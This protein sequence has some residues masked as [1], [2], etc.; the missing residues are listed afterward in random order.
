MYEAQQPQGVGVHRPRLRGEAALRRQRRRS[1]TRRKGFLDAVPV[2]QA[3]RRPRRRDER[4]GRRRHHD[5]RGAPRRR[6]RT[7]PLIAG[8]APDD[9][10]G[11]I[12]TSG[13]TG[14]P[15]GVILTHCN[16]ASNVSAV[17][18]VFPLGARP[19]ARSRSSPGRT[20]RADRASSTRSS[21][22]GAS[23]ALCEAVDKIIDNLAEVQPDA[24][25]QRAAHLQP[26][27]HGGAEA[28]RRRS[29]SRSRT[30][31]EGR[32]QGHRQGA[33]RRAPRRSR[34]L[35]LAQLVDKLVFS[36][37]RAR[38][39]GRL[40]YAVQRRRGHLARGGRVHRLARHHRL[41]GLRPHRDEPH[42]HGQLPRRAEDRQ[43]RPRHPGRAHRDRRRHRRAQAAPRTASR[44][45]YEGEIVVY[46]PNVMKG[47]HNRPEENAAVF[48]KDGGFRTGDMGYLDA[49]GFLYITG[50]IKE[51]YKLENGKYV[52]P[53]P[54]EEQ[55][56]LSPL[57]RQRDGLRRQQARSTWRSS[58]P[59]STR[60]Q[61][62]GAKHG[63][64]RAGDADALLAERAGARALQ[65]GDREARAG[66]SRASS[67]SRT[68]RSSPRTSRPTTGC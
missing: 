20:L 57:R 60:V 50:R 17:H 35:A 66:S 53:T 3:H 18:E 62:V 43:R 39:G 27:L 52:V 48:T 51:Q 32:A 49:H 38:F 54:L 45:R 41:R 22:M 59:T 28:D 47:Y 14:N 55:L 46:G 4:R 11:L 8:P 2:A 42:R 7:A 13:T 25:L 9:I 29:R 31:V 33:R 16:I 58:S 61:E 68:S 63:M 65:A 23:M 67:P 21:R 37:V 15:K 26:H 34:E 6:A 36:K 12:Y 5:L 64:R 30:L 19:T 24:P 56:K 10:A 44:A 1:S 40:K